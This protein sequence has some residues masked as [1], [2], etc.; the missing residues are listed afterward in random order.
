MV[1]KKSYNLIESVGPSI[2]KRKQN[3]FRQ[4]RYTYIKDFSWLHFYN[5]PT[6]REREQVLDQHFYIPISVTHIAYPRSS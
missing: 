2:R 5:D 6:V 4:F 1:T 3:Q